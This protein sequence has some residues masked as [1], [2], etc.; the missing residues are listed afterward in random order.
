MNTAP[1]PLLVGVG[2]ASQRF[3]DPTH[4]AEPIVLMEQALRNA[5]LD[6]GNA[7]ML[8]AAQSVAVPKGMWGYRDP[9]R[10]LIEKIGATSARSSLFELGVLQTSLLARACEAI[11]AGTLDIAIVVGGEA[12][13]RSLRSA[14]TGLECPESQQAEDIAPD[15]TVVPSVDVLHRVEIE[16][17]LAVPARQYAILESAMRAADG[18]SIADHASKLNALWS[19]FSAIAVSNVDAWNRS[20]VISRMYSAFNQRSLLKSNRALCRRICGRSNNSTT[21]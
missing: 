4:S 8:S 18:L 11:G 2:I 21:S 3:D 20:L 12:K 10:L 1:V 13:F 19:G 7:A 17:G 9:A 16:R 15:D 5:A 6:C 14:I